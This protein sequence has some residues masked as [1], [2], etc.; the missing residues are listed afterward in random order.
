MVVPFTMRERRRRR[1]KVGR[2]KCLNDHFAATPKPYDRFHWF[3][4]KM[5]PLI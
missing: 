2:K 3:S 5:M 4:K 1:R